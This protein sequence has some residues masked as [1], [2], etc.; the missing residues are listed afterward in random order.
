MNYVLIIV[1]FASMSGR[2]SMTTIT[3]EFK[4]KATCQA[5]EKSTLDSLRGNATV[6]S[7]DCHQK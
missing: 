4:S 2:P 1:V 7:S 3:A 5:A 6:L